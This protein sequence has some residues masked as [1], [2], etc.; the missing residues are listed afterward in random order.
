M[1]VSLVAYVKVACDNLINTGTR[2]Y[3]DDDANF[4]LKFHN[5]CSFTGLRRVTSESRPI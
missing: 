5:V 4:L 2:R 1:I 3:G